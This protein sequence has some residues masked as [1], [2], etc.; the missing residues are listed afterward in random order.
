M[1]TIAIGEESPSISS[2]LSHPTS[3]WLSFW[4]DLM[5]TVLTV[6]DDVHLLFFNQVT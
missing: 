5:Y 4:N 2:T 1:A 3:G 6:S